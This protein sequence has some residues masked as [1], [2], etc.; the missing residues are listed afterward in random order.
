MNTPKTRHKD[1][2]DWYRRDGSIAHVQGY[3][4]VLV[5]RWFGVRMEWFERRVLAKVGPFAIR[6]TLYWDRAAIVNTVWPHVWWIQW[7]GRV[8]LPRAIALR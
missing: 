6:D 8:R 3:R 4:V 2:D 5:R 1:D 7:R